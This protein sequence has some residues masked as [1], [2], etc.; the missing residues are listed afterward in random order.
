MAG[1]AL[2]SRG[3]DRELL[4]AARGGNEAAFDALVRFHSPALLAL[5]RQLGATPE[6]AEDALQETLLSAHRSLSRFR[7]EASFRTW[8]SR[9]AVNAYRDLVRATR[10]LIGIPAPRTRADAS[11]RAAQRETVRRVLR[12]VDE[13]P[14]RQRETLLL[15]LREDLSYDEIGRR[16]GIGRDAVRMNLVAARKTLLARFSGEVER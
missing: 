11:E 16:L 5:L 15:R 7:G 8:L 14:P 6:D 1:E 3:E 12:A 13:L 4:A 10:N 2:P 9:I